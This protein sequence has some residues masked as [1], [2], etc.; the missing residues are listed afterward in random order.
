MTPKGFT[1]QH[2]PTVNPLDPKQLNNPIIPPDEQQKIAAT[3]TLLYNNNVSTLH[4]HVYR[5][6]PDGTTGAVL[7]PSAV[8]YTAYD[9]LGFGRG[10]GVH[11]I[12]VDN[13]T[14]EKYYTNNHYL[15]FYHIEVHENPK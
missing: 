9:V 13:G 4:P 1:V 15:S 14:E 2:I 6:D 7:P 3:L 8:G 5:N 11:R 10:R 12:I